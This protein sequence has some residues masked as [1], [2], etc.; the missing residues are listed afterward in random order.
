MITVALRRVDLSKPRSENLLGHLPEGI[1]ILPNTAG[2]STVEDASFTMPLPMS[3]PA[4]SLLRPN[5]PITRTQS[6]I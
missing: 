4:D 5:S 3:S 1:R 2:C 6:E